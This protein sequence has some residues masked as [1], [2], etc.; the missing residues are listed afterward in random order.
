MINQTK[1]SFIGTGTMGCPII[2]K[3]LDKFNRTKVDKIDKK[4]TEPAIATGVS[5]VI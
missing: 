5:S 1:V 2:F 3:L 4:A